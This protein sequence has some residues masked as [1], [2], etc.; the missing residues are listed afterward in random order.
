MAHEAGIEYSE[1][2]EM[3][4]NGAYNRRTGRNLWYAKS[5]Q[6]QNIIAL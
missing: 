6:N 4:L 3:L 2:L 5:V 1:L